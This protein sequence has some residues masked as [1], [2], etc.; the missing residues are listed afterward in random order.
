MSHNVSHK[1]IL[2]DGV[3]NL[4]NSSVVF[5]IK[6]DKKDVFRFAALQSN[7]GMVLV[8]EHDI[9]T[10]KT[11]SII[12]IDGNKS[13]EKSSAAL[14]I[15]KELSGAYPLLYGF[16]I[17]PKFIRNRIYDYIAKNRYRWYGKKESCMIPTP[18]LKSKFL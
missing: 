18:E 5:I 12:L 3:C 10:S 16:M 7:V 9:D 2:F 13:Y 15:A 11:D 6:R 14:R 4:C 17:I 8:N 1:I